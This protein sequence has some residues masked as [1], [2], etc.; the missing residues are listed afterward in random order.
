MQELISFEV[1][2][3]PSLYESGSLLC[4]WGNQHRWQRWL[5]GEPFIG[6][7]VKSFAVWFFE[8][9]SKKKSK[10]RHWFFCIL[11]MDYWLATNVYAIKARGPCMQG[12]VVGTSAL[13]NI[14]AWYMRPYAWKILP[15][16]HGTL[17]L[18]VIIKMS[19][20]SSHATFG[21]VAVLSKVWAH[22][23]QCKLCYF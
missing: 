9:H 22:H 2:S 1:H 10:R 16:H 20:I 21:S 14:L 5:C 15:R 12:S 11:A 7:T 13:K 18:Y 3:N 19:I 17:H 8:A 23:S 6:H 4:A